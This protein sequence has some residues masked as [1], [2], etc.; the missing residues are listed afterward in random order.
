MPFFGGALLAIG[1]VSLGWSIYALIAMIVSYRRTS[2]DE[3]LG[4][5]MV[6]AVVVL[7]IAAGIDLT[8]VA[9]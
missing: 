1:L 7:M 5:S 6:L 3:V 9:Q 8:G 4:I 2:K